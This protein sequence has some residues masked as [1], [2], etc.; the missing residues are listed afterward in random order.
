MA[1]GVRDAA[2]A[3]SASLA[4]AAEFQVMSSRDFA[5]AVSPGGTCSSSR[6]DCNSSESASIESASLSLKTGK[7]GRV[8]AAEGTISVFASDPVLATSSP[9]LGFGNPTG[10][11]SVSLFYPATVAP[12]S[13]GTELRFGDAALV[14]GCICR[15]VASLRCGLD[16]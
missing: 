15:N 14:A 6:G 7:T 5:S 10:A 2:R 12:C 4:L 9:D 16:G 13:P 11:E 3:S 1:P 8:T